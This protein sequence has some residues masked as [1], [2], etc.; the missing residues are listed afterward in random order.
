MAQNEL[1]RVAKAFA[2]KIE[3]ALLSVAAQDELSKAMAAEAVDVI[4]H[5]TRD[6]KGVA[7]EGGTLQ[8]LKP[9]S[10][11]YIERRRHSRL[12]SFTSP[13]KS[14]LTFTS[15]LL[16]A[17]GIKRFKPG[18]WGVAFS[19]RHESGIANDLLSTYVS[20][21]R[22]FVNLSRD[23][24]SRVTEIGRRTFDDLVKRSIR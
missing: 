24:T 14:N 19:G 21:E 16:S 12:S 13:R 5:R 18:Q 9:L 1:G 17:M 3:K 4:L 22:P 15:E 6:G 10:K 7:G 20:R 8:R 11:A 23:E 2:A